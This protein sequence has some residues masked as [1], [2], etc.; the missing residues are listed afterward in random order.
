MRSALLMASESPWLRERAPRYRFIRRTVERFLPGENLD[1]ALAAAQRLAEDRH[2][3]FA[4]ASRRELSPIAPKPKRS[5]S[6]ILDVLDRIRAA[7]LA[8]RK[9]P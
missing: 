5:R 3:H 4:H 7:R 8:R 2:R 6:I 9:F 1:D